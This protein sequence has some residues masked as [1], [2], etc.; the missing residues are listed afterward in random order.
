MTECIV[1]AILDEILNSAQL[2][3]T[4]GCIKEIIEI[5][6]VVR[7]VIVARVDVNG[8]GALFA[9]N[10]HWVPLVAK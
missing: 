10:Q 4:M 9:W 8:R 1:E 7:L 6:I 3:P 5:P 2:I